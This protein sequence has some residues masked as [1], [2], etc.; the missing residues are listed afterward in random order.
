MTVNSGKFLRVNLS[1]GKITTESI[2]EQI[3]VDF[4]GG[5]GYGVRYLYQELNPHVDPFGEENKVILTN[6]PLAGT[7]A[8]TVSRWMALTKSPLTGAFARSVGGSDFGAWLK[9]AGYDFV[10][11]E[12]KAEHPVYV[13]ITKDSAEIRDGRELW[14]M[15]TTETQ[16][17]LNDLHGKSV[18]AA[19]IGPA[20]ERLVRY[21]GIFSGRR[22]AGRTGTGAVLGSKNLKAIAVN[23]SRTLHLADEAN[24]TK[25]AKEQVKT[26]TANPGYVNHK[27][28]GTMTTQEVTNDIGIYPV[29]NFRDG[30]LV[31]NEK[32]TGAEYRKLRTGDIGC[33]SCPAR[34]GKQHKVTAGLYK[35]AC[36]EGPEYE[37]IWAFSGTINSSN[38]EATIAADQLC[39]DFGMDTISTGS[40]IGFAF[41]LFEKGILTKKDCDGLDLKYGNH[42]AMI[43]LIK[44]I[45]AREGIGN[46]LAEGSLRA[47]ASIG[48][49]SEAYSIQVKGLE[50]PAYE[51]RGAKAQ[52]YNYA[53]ASIGASH[54][55]GYAAQ[56]VF[57]APFPRAVD[58]FSEVDKADI[59]IF[60]QDGAARAEVGIVCT[61]AAGWGWVPDI[62]GKMLAASRGIEQLADPKHLATVGERIFNLERAFNVREGLGRKDD[63]L[64]K[65][66]LTEPLHVEGAPGE[67]QIVTQ[68]DEFL[69]NYYKLRGWT[70]D[71]VPTA[72]KLNDMG[73]GFAAKDLKAK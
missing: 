71:G 68:Q 23:A 13:Y 33:Y 57:G 2:P 52:G 9:F 5:R 67:G 37:S 45:A 8:I 22:C 14:G 42:E 50:L 36:S 35:G 61:F 73:L 53:T 25:W 24:Y 15:N 55:Y 7:S 31:G 20:G 12:G 16:D 58:R 28:W 72:K 10:I 18:R 64:P 21:A 46:L 17:R 1:S 27:E 51:P 66:M 29:R 59:V 56:E 63:T 48:K 41:E 34:C 43:S 44:K 60:N 4:V 39:D 49:G 38:L 54:C 30:R 62:F 19:V 40:T 32:L 70:K 69:D 47:A 3:A 26:I 65:R 11:I 6:G